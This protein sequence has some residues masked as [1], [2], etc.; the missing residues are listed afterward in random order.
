VRKRLTFIVASVAAIAVLLVGGTAA[1]ATQ[2]DDAD[3]QEERV[4]G[5]AADQA[6]AAALREAGG[7]SVVEMERDPEGQR[8]YKVEVQRANGTTVDVNL[9]GSFDVVAEADDDANEANERDDNDDNEPDD[10]DDN[11]PDDRND[12]DD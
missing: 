12:T 6:R 10:R 4:T 5:E 3:S 8:I 9:N 2:T 1:V 7:G 11:D